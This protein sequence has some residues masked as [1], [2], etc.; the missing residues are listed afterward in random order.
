MNSQLCLPTYG[1]WMER[2]SSSSS[3][4]VE[5][6]RNAGL[7]IFFRGGPIEGLP[8]A[9]SRRLN[10]RTLVRAQVALSEERD[11]RAQTSI[12]QARSG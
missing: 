3:A 9:L 8:I 6:K 4:P 5:W 10:D 11:M 2:R 1:K 7:W 12:H